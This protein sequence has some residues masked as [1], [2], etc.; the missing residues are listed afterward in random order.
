MSK[1]HYTK[2]F[3]LVLLVVAAFLR[4]WRIQELTEFLGDQGRTG[5]IIYEAWK[6]RQLPLVGPPVLT[7]QFLGPAFYYIIG[8]PFIFGGFHPVVP[9]VFM[10]LLGVLAV[11]LLYRLAAAIFG[12]WIGI[13]VAGLYAVSPLIVRADRTLWEPTAVPLFVLLYLWCVYSVFEKRRY[14][15]LLP[16]GAIVGVLVQ[17]HY[18]NIF[19]VGLSVGLL[20]L[21]LVR[22]KTAKKSVFLWFLV[23]IAGFLLVL[24]PFLWYESQHAWA[25]IRE[26]VLILAFGGAGGQASYS[27]SERILDASYKLF[28]HLAPEAPK[29][30]IMSLQLFV[31]AAVFWRRTFWSAFLAGWYVLGIAAIALYRGVVF[32]HYLFFLLPLPYLLL[33]H[34]VWSLRRYIPMYV[35]IGLI[36]LLVVFNVQ[37]TDIF[38][39]GPNDI[40]RVQGIVNEIF[41]SA[42]DQ[43]FSFTLT[44]SRSFSDFHYRYFFKLADVEPKPITDLSY[45]ALFLICDLEPC[46]TADQ[47]KKK[48]RVQAIC[49]ERHCKGSYP[50]VD[51]SDWKLK[52]TL[53]APDGLIYMFRVQ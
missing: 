47:M 3:V 50:S 34:A 12:T 40:S 23:G 8:L 32:Y 27:Y 46:P 35:I 9:S 20:L 38:S 45:S 10:A 11:F 17:L 25:D 42:K 33:G 36:G 24:S 44:S 21:L 43:P 2:V 29:R 31:L 22:K 48:I 30:F 19:Y 52:A 51:L 15:Y 6:S 39:P 26:I 13:A 4:L 7:G 16:M 41:V 37:K 14:W 53:Y 5:M 49:F 28:G 1:V 18:P